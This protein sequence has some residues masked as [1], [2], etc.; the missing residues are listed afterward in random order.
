MENKIRHLEMIQA[1][2]TRLSSNSFLIKGWTVALLAGLFALAAK[3]ANQ[4][5]TAVAYFPLLAFWF[6][7]AYF[8]RA[9]WRYRGLFNHV[10]KLEDA[11]IDFLMDADGYD[12]RG[13]VES[14]ISKTLLW[15][16][17]PLAG[18]ILLV[19]GLVR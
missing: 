11:N 9:E 17:S 12:N 6:L 8:L 2:I 10:R 4:H 15:F 3:D 5:F 7:D 1:V 14:L 16:Y 19:C 13:V 18:V